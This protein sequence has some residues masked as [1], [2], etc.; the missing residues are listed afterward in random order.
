M[1]LAALVIGTAVSTP[2]IVAFLS[3][4]VGL[5]SQGGHAAVVVGAVVFSTPFIIG[6]FRIARVLGI[7]LAAAALPEV[8]EGKL[9]LAA[10]P[11]RALI[12]TIQLAIALL[13]GLPL[14]ALTQPF[15]PSWAA[16][17]TF[18][19]VLVSLGIG[20]WRSA[21]NLQGHVRAGAEMIVEALMLQARK[22]ASSDA[23]SFSQVHQ[24]LPGLGEPV[25]LR[26]T[27]TSPAV[28]KT[29]AEIN[30]RGITGASVL[31]IARGDQGV[32][33]P[34]ASEV[35]RAE[36]VLALA[37]THDAV[38]AATRTLQGQ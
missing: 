12:V 29:L 22:P 5:S 20:F 33:V 19:L 14:L 1:V 25:P 37:G 11:R 4:K 23:A 13:V 24:L 15:L 36:D 8:G 34:T 35:L 6:I 30:L 32:I 28:G 7:S 18:G 38:A 27:A 21:T 17:L 26:L 10:A 9:D 16:G 3:A 31:A 2:T